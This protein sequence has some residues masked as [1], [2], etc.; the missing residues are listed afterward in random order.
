MTA[1]GQKAKYS[2]RAHIVRFAPDSGLKLDTA[3]GPF[4]ANKRLMHRTK[5]GSF[6]QLCRLIKP[7]VDLLSQQGKIN[8]LGE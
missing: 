5:F 8:R 7:R 2:L 1:L 4:G 3:E 6:D